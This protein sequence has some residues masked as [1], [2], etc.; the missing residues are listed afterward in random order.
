MDLSVTSTVRFS[1]REPCKTQRGI[2][3]EVCLG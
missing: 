1:N 3:M 2:V